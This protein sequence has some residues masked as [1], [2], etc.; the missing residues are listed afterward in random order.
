MAASKA[1]Q[2]DSAALEFGGAWFAKQEVDVAG[3]ERSAQPDIGLTR[4][5]GEI[6]SREIAISLDYIS[7]L[8]STP[9]TRGRRRPSTW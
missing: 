1:V 6:Q 8:G 9:S 4:L 7:R 2:L 5:V 3:V